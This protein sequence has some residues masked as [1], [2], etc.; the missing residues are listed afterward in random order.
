[1]KSGLS[2][3]FHFR[4]F[5]SLLCSKKEDSKKK[6]QVKHESKLKAFIKRS[7]EPLLILQNTQHSQIVK[8]KVKWNLTIVTSKTIHITE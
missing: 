2:D 3:F 4:V 7:S 6:D 8:E 5:Q 1:M